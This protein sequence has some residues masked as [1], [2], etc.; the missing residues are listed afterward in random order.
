MLKFEDR[1]IALRDQEIQE[2]KER[3]D[4]IRRTAQEGFRA[5]SDQNSRL[6]E[7]LDS[8]ELQDRFD[9]TLL[10]ELADAHAEIRKLKDQVEKHEWLCGHAAGLAD[11]LAEARETIARLKACG[12]QS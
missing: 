9:T 1:I 8:Y 2:L 5:L 6:K 3:V 10:D 4:S 11:S 7:Q 12:V